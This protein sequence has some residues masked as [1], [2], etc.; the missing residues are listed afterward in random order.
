MKKNKYKLIK[1]YLEKNSKIHPRK[2]NNLLKEQKWGPGY[3]TG[4]KADPLKD[5]DIANNFKPSFT[6]W[7]SKNL[8]SI[9]FEL[10]WNV[11]IIIIVNLII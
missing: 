11:L 4:D 2:F 3:D 1:E 7:N 10:S 8:F 6:P 5:I 9:F